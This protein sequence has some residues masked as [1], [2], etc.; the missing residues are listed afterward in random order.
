MRFYENPL[1]TS[2]NREKQRA[3]YIP[4]GSAKYTSLNGEWKFKFF[5]NS[6]LATEPENWDTIEVPSCWQLKGY[7]NPNYTNINFPFP[8]DMPY[9]PN[10]NPMGMYERD[11]E[12]SDISKEAYVVLEGVCSC[13]VVYINESY[14]GYTQGSHLQ[15]EFKISKYVKQGK[16]TIRIKVYKWSCSTYI[17]DQDMFRYNG[18]FRDIYVLEREK[19]HIKDIDIRTQDNK[20]IVV[21]A[22]K[23][24]NVKLYDGNELVGEKT[25]TQCTFN[26]KKPKLWT[27][28]T[29]YLYTV[30]LTRGNEVI[31]QKIG[32]RSIKVSDKY[33]I[34]IN[35]TPIKIKGINHHDTM[36]GKGYCM[37]D[38]DMRRD[39][40]LMKELNINC[41]RTSH[42]P[43]HPKFVDMCDEMGFYV[44]LECDN[45]AHGML[46]RFPNVN[47]DYDVTVNEWPCSHPDW[48]NEHEER[49]ARTYERDKNHASIIMWSLGNEAGYHSI[50]NDPMI[51]YI[52]RRDGERL[53]HFESACWRQEG[54]DKTD[55]Y[56]CMY[57]SMERVVKELTINDRKKPIY[58]CEF[59]HAMG[60]GPGDVWQY[61]DLMYKY[62]NY[63][64]GCI[65]E[66]AD[67]VVVVDG[68]QKYGGDFPGELTHDGNFCCDGLVFADRSFKAGTL[69][70]KVAYAP[71]RFEYK[72][73]R[74]KITN[75]YDFTNIAD[76]KFKYTVR[77]DDK[78]VEQKQ[79]SLKLAPKKS[80]FVKI[81]SIPKECKYG[82]N[83]D[84][85]MFNPQGESLGMLS[86][87][88][89][90]KKI[91]E[92]KDLKPATLINDGN[93]IYA[94]GE[95]FEYRY[96]KQIG[97]F[98]SLIVNGEELLAEGVKL[99]TF[100]A[101]TDNDKR[102]H[103][104]WIKV[105]EWKGENID[106]TTTK[107]YDVSVNKNTITA[108]CSL[109]GISRLPYFNYKLKA[110]IYSNGTISYALTG[111]VRK[112]TVWLPR[113]GFEFS[114]IGKDREFTYFGMGPSENYC[115]MC[116]HVRQDWFR[117]SADTE[118]VPYVRPQEHG[119]HMNTKILNIDD[120]LVFTAKNFE[121][122]VSNYS[123]EQLHKAN[124]TNEI[125]E[126]KVTHVRIDYKNSGVG[127]SS[128]GPDLEPEYC[129]NE[130]NISF[131]FDLSII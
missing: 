61:V 124:H 39:L 105:T 84:V 1:K 58:F 95:N 81:D 126:S 76:Y 82:A 42:Y 26:V 104:L 27:A 16:N 73:G 92:K 37:T 88:I 15:A 85:E 4:K 103:D 68:V 2:E 128:C 28:E 130:K 57:P 23:K 44:V 83:I 48:A 9:V 3:Y 54:I 41:V 18:I 99:S 14:V 106:Y 75:H 30:I 86:Q 94:S 69:E 66:W 100:R 110:T 19:N 52:R 116:H 21:K 50:C 11:F 67:H 112:D 111:E 12:I 20:K 33:E 7:E 62:D 77:V 87:S 91:V 80:A 36:I 25:G 43:P 118:Y 46:R 96:N 117:S 72:A 29:P 35:G 123:I 8:C 101:L 5:E 55:V 22:D 89:E 49:M 17:E 32:I 115:D 127:S 109:G 102:M 131:K 60:N 71:F 114:L 34:L 97:N 24:A 31:E 98:D 93:F 56:S 53:I 74:I 125:G 79:F 108:E 10:I 59:S 64:G 38:E 78:S 45:E 113:L 120:K 107:V 65:W 63:V 119:N 47:Y 51:E 122:N 40:E 90:C 6:D 129:L 13:A 70:T 121:F